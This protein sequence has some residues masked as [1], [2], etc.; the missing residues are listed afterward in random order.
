MAGRGH[1][2]LRR[3]RPPRGTL[4]IVP[5]IVLIAVLTIYPVAR[6][7]AIAFGNGLGNFVQLFESR[8][9]WSTLRITLYISVET[10]AVSLLLGYPFAY[11]VTAYRREVAQRLLLI[12]VA[13]FWISLIV[14]AYAWM[15]ILGRR[16]VVNEFLM[17]LG[18]TQEPLALL[19]SRPAVTIGMVHYLLPYMILA[20]YAGMNGIDRRLMSAAQTLGA[21]SFQAFRRVFLPLSLPAIFAGSTL[22]F[23]LATGF[24]V[25]PSLLGGAQ[26]MTLAVYIERQTFFLNWDLASSAAVLLAGVSLALFLI[27]DKLIGLDELFGAV[28]R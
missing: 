7:I 1:S 19:F 21:S 14:R 20:L 10:T 27:V 2:L 6:I 11:L 25:V 8:V 26:E 13:T 28:R 22:V 18:I 17:T 12:V 15:V 23:I 24:F 4:V 16:G 3:Y 9:F 5:A